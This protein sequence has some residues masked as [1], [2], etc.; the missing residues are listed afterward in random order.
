M[1]SAAVCDITGPSAEIVFIG[2]GDM[3]QKG[4]GIHMRLWSRAYVIQDALGN[5]VVLVSA[6]VG[7]IFRSVEQ[8]VVKKLKERFGNIYHT[9]NVLLQANHTH[10]GPGGYSHY[11]IYNVPNMGF[12]K[13]NY[14]VIVEGIFQSI[15]RAHNNLAPGKILINSGDLD[16]CGMNRSLLAYENNPDEVRHYG[17]W[18]NGNPFSSTFTQ[19]V[20][21][22]GTSSVFTVNP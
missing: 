6:D 12:V 4:E 7:M 5:R 21:Y 20:P 17:Y 3:N 19:T 18:K 1:K 11:F 9:K 16:E 13:Q 22:Q 14:E 15:V 8:G 2:F 10:A